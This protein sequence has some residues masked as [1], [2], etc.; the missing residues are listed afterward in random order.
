MGYGVKEHGLDWQSRFP[1]NGGPMVVVS[2][3]VIGSRDSVAGSSHYPRELGRP[4]VQLI[5]R[6][7]NHQGPS[8]DTISPSELAVVSR[9]DMV[10]A[11]RLQL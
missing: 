8:A 2:N 5:P 9:Q 6:A 7:D 11:S 3:R 4:M 10:R 1:L